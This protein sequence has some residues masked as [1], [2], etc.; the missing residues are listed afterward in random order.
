MHLLAIP[1]G[2][3]TFEEI[4]DVISSTQIGYHEKPVH[5]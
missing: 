5:F 3:G 1:G 4:F 2:Y